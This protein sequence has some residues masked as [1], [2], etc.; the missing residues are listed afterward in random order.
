MKFELLRRDLDTSRRMISYQKL[1]VIVS[2]TLNLVTCLIAYRLIGL[3]RTILVPPVV[4]KTF[5]VDSDKVSA[6]YLEQM[7]YFLLQLVLNV[8]PQSVD[9][10]SKLL[11]Q[12][13]APASYGEIKTAMAVVAERLKRDGASTVFSPRSLTTDERELKVA[14]QGSLTTFIGD[15]RVSETNKA[16]LVE[17]QYALGKLYIKSFKE[18]NANDPLDTKANAARIVAGG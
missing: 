2:L 16:Y 17:L 18:V 5:W 15:R 10:Q 8:S 7:G 12:Y 1:I 9:Y 3:E 11:L 4:H 13:A 6:E 14:V